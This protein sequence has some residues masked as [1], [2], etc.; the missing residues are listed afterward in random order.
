MLQGLCSRWGVLWLWSQHC[1]MLGIVATLDKEGRPSAEHE[2]FTEVYK[3]LPVEC[4]ATFSRFWCFLNMDGRSSVREVLP[5]VRDDSSHL[6][7]HIAGVP[8]PLEM[9]HISIL[10]CG[11]SN[12][13]TVS[14]TLYFT[15]RS[16]YITI[17]C[18]SFASRDFNF[19]WAHFKENHKQ[20]NAASQHTLGAVFFS[21]QRGDWNT[22]QPET[23]RV[24]LP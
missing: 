12:L 13:R 9:A 24:S 4:W 20:K 22:S 14:W 11:T 23:L 15:F 2:T 6:C 3:L 21:L 18:I 17:L 10:M 1:S 8:P 7:W 19:S 5:R 16:R